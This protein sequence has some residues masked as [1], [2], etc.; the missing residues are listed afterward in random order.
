M[1]ERPD[2]DYAVPILERELGGRRIT[3]VRVKKPIV[4]RL[5][6][7]GTPAELLVGRSFGE[8][9]RRAHFAVL[10]LGPLD[11]SS[12][13]APIDL[14][15]A[16]MLAGRFALH[17]DEKVPGDLAVALT[18]DDGR[19][20]R[21][22]DDVQMGKVYVVPR[23][24]RA[25]VPGLAK[26][27]VDVLDPG[28]F[29]LDRFKKLARSRRDQA[30]VFLMDKSA[31]DALGNAYADESLFEARVHPKS[32]VKALGDDELAA[33][34]RA[35]PEV[36]ARAN[37]EIAARKPAIDVKLRDFL[38]VRGRHLQPCPRCATPIR[39]AG[40]HGHDA[41]FCPTCQPE[42]RKSAIVSWDKLAAAR[43]AKEAAGPRQDAAPA[44]D[45]AEE[46]GPKNK[47]RVRTP[48][49]TRRRR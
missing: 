14:V 38:H 31:L 22:R 27:G 26:I 2:L 5:A 4:L 44:P 12:T 46:P 28:A 39:T 30:K 37:A 20:L 8:V 45:A 7:P 21:Y 47:K 42:T 25:Q 3:A 48:G 19:E 41:Y 36:L 1:A 13:P 24:D 40:V 29:T 17:T 34:H 16:P 33:L 49:A 6:L 18:L 43:A 35:I 32:F 9:Y 10:E 15:V 11:G 23:G